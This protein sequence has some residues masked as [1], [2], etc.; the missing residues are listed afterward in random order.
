MTRAG[1]VVHVIQAKAGIGLHRILPVGQGSPMD[2]HE[3]VNIGTDESFGLIH[4]NGL[5]I[6]ICDIFHLTSP[7]GKVAIIPYL[8]PD[9]IP[10]MPWCQGQRRV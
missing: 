1:L 7:D 8:I 3:I 5:T 9:H 6:A 10:V 4:G 2:L